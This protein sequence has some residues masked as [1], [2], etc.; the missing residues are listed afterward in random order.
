MASAGKALAD[1][2]RQK[3]GGEVL[4]DPSSCERYASDYSIYRVLPQAV[5]IPR[6]VED[7]VNA[8]QLAGDADMPVTARGGGSSTAGSATGSGIIMLLNR[9]GGLNGIGDIQ[10]DKGDVVVTAQAGVRHDDLQTHL[11]REGFFLPADP[12]SGGISFIGGN[13]ATKASGPHALKHGSI[14]RYL[15]HVTFVTG[16]GTVI[17]TARPDSIPHTLGQGVRALRDRIRADAVASAKL[18]ARRDMKCAS[19]YNLGAMRRGLSD[20]ELLTQCLV[21]SVGTLGVVVDATLRGE[22]YDADRATSLL[23]FRSLEEAAAAACH[24]R[25]QGVA[26]IEMMNT[27]AIQIVRERHPDLPLPPG[28]V[29]MLLVEYSGSARHE[30][31]ATVEKYLADVGCKLVIA[32]ETVEEPERQAELWRARKALLP[33]I[34]NYRPDRKAWSIVNDVGVDAQYLADF[35]RDVEAVFK[36]HDLIAP[37]YGHAGSGNL[38]L[39]PFFNPA[40]PDVANT[41]QRVADEVYA[42]VCRYG[43]TITA[44]HGMG[45]LRAPYLEQEWG[46]VMVSYMKDLK[47]L[48]DPSGLLNP[49]VMFGNTRLSETITSLVS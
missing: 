35:I 27:T 40:D 9:L 46:S 18:D 45:R 33:L 29:N 36:R 5:V 15:Q 42:A 30:Q 8:I 17:N 28:D 31:I 41:V 25:T 16:D 26:A 1:K 13:V 4:D 37:I 14:D 23:C 6:D 2:L 49:G 19:G 47:D 43:G 44:E 20:G 3:I 39:R 22:R 12:S 38:H 7:I 11:R 24:I 48:F 34:R 32:P 21:G 10:N